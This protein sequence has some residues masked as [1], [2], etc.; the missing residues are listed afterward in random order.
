VA[1]ANQARGAF[2]EDL[3]ARWY[4]ARGY[5]V[6]DRNWRRA[7]VGELD[8]VLGRPVGRSSVGLVVFCEVKTR[9]STAFGHPFEAVNATKLERIRRLGWA[10]L[11]EHDLKHVRMRVDVAAVLGATGAPAVEVL[12]DL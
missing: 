2:G 8:L 9:S 11:D 7:R 12:H 5:Q 4:A 1:G 6:L 10:W 3:V